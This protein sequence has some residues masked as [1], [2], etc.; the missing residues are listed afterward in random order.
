[1]A[2]FITVCHMSCQAAP[3]PD[4][5][6]RRTPFRLLLEACEYP[7]CKQTHLAHS[8]MNKIQDNQFHKVSHCAE[9]SAIYGLHQHTR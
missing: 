1:M 6:M 2:S 4:L 5:L 8:H 3:D 9:A 7:A